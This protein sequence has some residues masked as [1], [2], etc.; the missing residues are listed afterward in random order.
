MIVTKTIFSHFFLSYD[1]EQTNDQFFLKIS[2]L[3]G[4]SPAYF[5]ERELYSVDGVQLR[6]IVMNGF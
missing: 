1:C 3:L 4:K 2:S 6:T 5:L